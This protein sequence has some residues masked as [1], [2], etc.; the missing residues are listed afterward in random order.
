[1]AVLK[2]TI[3]SVHYL[4]NGHQK[5]IENLPDRQVEE[6]PDSVVE[7]PRFLADE[8]RSVPVSQFF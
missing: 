5:W 1:M 3:L 6:H 2:K 7:T 4:S 8:G